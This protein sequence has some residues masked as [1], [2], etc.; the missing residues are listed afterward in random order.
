MWVKTCEEKLCVNTLLFPKVLCNR[1]DKASYT[2][3]PFDQSAKEHKDA[4]LFFYY[5]QTR[6]TLY[7]QFKET[8]WI[9]R[10]WPQSSASLHTTMP[11]S[12]SWYRIM[13]LILMHFQ[14][15]V[16]LRKQKPTVWC[17]LASE[18][19]TNVQCVYWETEKEHGV[20]LFKKGGRFLLEYWR[21]RRRTEASSVSATTWIK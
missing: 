7:Y 17:E 1:F 9:L 14:Q 6:M 18:T 15:E 11:T 20:P 12:F 2:T 8:L 10:T 13:H 3:F 5:L 21:R 19:K 16:C 4:M